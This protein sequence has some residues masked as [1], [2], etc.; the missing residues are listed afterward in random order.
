M[1]QRDLATAS[2]M[3]NTYVSDIE[4][5]KQNLTMA[6]MQRI[7]ESLNVDVGTLMRAPSKAGKS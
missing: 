7:A 1:T 6:V 5:G 2:G 4:R 3:S